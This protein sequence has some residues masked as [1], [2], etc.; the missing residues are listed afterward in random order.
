M[1]ENKPFMQLVMLQYPEQLK[2]SNSRRPVY[3]LQGEKIPGTL[4]GDE[5]IFKEITLRTQDG[6]MRKEYRLYNTKTKEYPLRNA[7]TKDTARY[8]RINGQRIWDGSIARHTRA[9]LASVLHEYFAGYT[10]QMATDIRT[11]KDHYL[12]L[13]FI[14]YY[15]FK[16][17]E[18]NSWQDVFNHSLCYTKTFE[19]TLV[20][21]GKVHTDSPAL[22]RGSYSRYVEVPEEDER[23]LVVKFYYRKNNE[24]I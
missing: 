23:R 10:E 13:E 6:R 2:L 22:Y 16:C 24:Q 12:H 4:R 15:P 17:R 3:Y 5:Y 11:P 20:E 18:P 19:D 21:T 1:Q 7:R 14:F 8:Q 9:K